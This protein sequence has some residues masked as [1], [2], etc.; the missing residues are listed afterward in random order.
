MN[1]SNIQR[2]STQL[3]NSVF[4][5]KV[6]AA[7]NCYNYATWKDTILFIDFITKWWKIINVRSSAVGI[8]KN[9]RF[10]EPICR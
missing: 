3:A 10:K 2:T 7:M 5:E 6:P 9:D 1:P 8:Q 4:N